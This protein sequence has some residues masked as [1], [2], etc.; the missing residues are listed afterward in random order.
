MKKQF[1]FL[2]ELNVSS[3]DLATKFNIWMYLLNKE[4]GY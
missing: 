2:I 3:I 1:S 4:K